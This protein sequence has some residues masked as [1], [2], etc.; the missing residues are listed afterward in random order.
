MEN[1]GEAIVTCM[2]VREGGRRVHEQSNI[3]KGEVVGAI[4]NLKCEKASGIDGIT[5]EML[6]YGGDSV[7]DWMHLM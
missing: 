6:K 4:Q 3:E 7:V 5:A 1:Q 2:C